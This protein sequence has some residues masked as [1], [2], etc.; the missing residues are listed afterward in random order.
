M[1]TPTGLPKTG[2]RVSYGIPL[3]SNNWKPDLMY[4]T[5]VE[6][7]TGSYWTLYVRWDP[8]YRTL[9]HRGSS[10]GRDVEMMVDASYALKQGWLKVIG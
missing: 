7:G 2:E 9:A 3:P 1:P 10:L 5:V 6:R 8:E 4:G